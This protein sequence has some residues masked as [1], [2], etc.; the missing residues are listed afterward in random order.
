MQLDGLSL[1][2]L[3]AAIR[4]LRERGMVYTIH[5]RG[6]FVGQPPTSGGSGRVQDAEK[7]P[8]VHEDAVHRSRWL[9]QAN[10]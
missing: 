5:A 7:A 8:D 2:T 9:D 10:R 6:T 1:G 4:L 3:R